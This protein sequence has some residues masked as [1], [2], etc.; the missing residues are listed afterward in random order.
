[1]ANIKKNVRKT[2]ANS[3]LNVG[4]LR[5]TQSNLNDLM[6]QVKQ[7]EKKYV[8]GSFYLTTDSNRLYFAQSETQLEHLN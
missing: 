2:A 8:A 3:N 7:S 5:G 4:F 1:M 6:S